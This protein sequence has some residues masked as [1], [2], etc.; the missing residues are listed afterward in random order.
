ML[1]W[2]GLRGGVALALALAL[3]EQLPER[4]LFVALTGGVVLATLLLN[5]TT[6]GALVHRL[7]LDTPSRADRF[8]AASAQLAGVETAR[9][10]LAELSLDEA[11]VE[12]ELDAAARA[13]EA[14][15]R[16][17]DLSSEEEQG[18]VVRR[19]L[20]I[21]RQTYQHL[22]DVGFLPPPT[23]RELLHEVDGK[24]EEATLRSGGLVDASRERPWL[25]RVAQRVTARLPGPV[26]VDED[27]LAYAE[28]TARRLAARRCVEAL[29]LFARLPN[30]SEVAVDAAKDVFRR[31][32]AEAMDSLGE[33]F[34]EA[35]PDGEALRRRLAATLSATAAED[36]L[37][38]LADVGLLSERAAT[39]AIARINAG[40]DGE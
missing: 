11:V 28:A 21:E 22:S 29:A 9:A 20:F 2:G 16:R 24:I 8:L 18:V 37:S 27:E 3:P 1:I 34:P 33:L 5:A 14:E 7:G 10:R 6:I 40:V 4:D 35:D 30:V 15:L 23:T 31:W 38:A 13:A 25:E 12:A 32:E 17:L 19:G 39:M 36:A 26:G